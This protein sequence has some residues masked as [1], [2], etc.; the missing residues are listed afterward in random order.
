MP[1]TPRCVA[2]YLED[3][4]EHSRRVSLQA[5]IMASLQRI[6]SRRFVFSAAAIFGMSA[7]LS[8]AFPALSSASELD[9]QKQFCIARGSA[10]GDSSYVSSCNYSD[11]QQCLQ[12]AVPVRG[13]CVG[14]IDYHGDTAPAAPAR[15][16]RRAR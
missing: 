7:L 12:A 8:L 16:S 4:A 1:V 6:P 3:M 13:N 2:P 14:N 11:Y 15:H 10:N 5:I 9:Q